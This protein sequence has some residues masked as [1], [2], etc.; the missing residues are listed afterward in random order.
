[1]AVVLLAGHIDNPQPPY[2]DLVVMLVA[3]LF[4]FF[5]LFGDSCTWL[6]AVTRPGVLIADVSTMSHMDMPHH[7]VLTG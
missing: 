2:L 4:L 6:H 1:M 7:A 3:F 5:L